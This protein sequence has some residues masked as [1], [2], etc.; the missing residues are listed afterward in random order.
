MA[1][2]LRSRGVFRTVGRQPLRAP[3]S[4]GQMKVYDDRGVEATLGAEEL[5]TL[6]TGETQTRSLASLVMFDKNKN[7]IWKYP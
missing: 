3:L 1:W 5:V 6:P 4:P 7:V 2:R